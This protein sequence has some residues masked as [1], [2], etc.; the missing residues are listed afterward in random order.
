MANPQPKTHKSCLAIS[1]SEI[2]LLLPRFSVFIAVAAAACRC[3]VVKFHIRISCGAFLHVHSINYI[4]MI[5]KRLA[6]TQC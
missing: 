5:A 3:G 1:A 4:A 6:L 2:F